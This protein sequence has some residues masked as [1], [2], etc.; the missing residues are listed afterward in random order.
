MYQFLSDT[1][2]AVHIPALT[3]QEKMRKIENFLCDVGLLH[4]LQGA[5][6]TSTTQLVCIVCSQHSVP[7]LPE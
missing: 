4:S 6:N 2:Y 5:S 3:Y 1:R 7:E